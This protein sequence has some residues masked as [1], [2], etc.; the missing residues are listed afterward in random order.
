MR[1]K[2]DIVQNLLSSPAHSLRLAY[3]TLAVDKA[4]AEQEIDVT[5]HENSVISS[6]NI[7]YGEFSIAQKLIALEPVETSCGI[8]Q[9]AK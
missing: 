8:G 4:E 1:A 6:M 9:S 5:F 3:F 2:L 7:D